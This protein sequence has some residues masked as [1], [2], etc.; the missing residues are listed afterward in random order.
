MSSACTVYRGKRPS[1]ICAIWFHIVSCCHCCNIDDL[2][3]LRVPSEKTRTM[4]T[5]EQVTRQPE[6]TWVYTV[7]TT[8][9]HNSTGPT[10]NLSGNAEPILAKCPVFQSDLV[11][12]AVSQRFP[13]NVSLKCVTNRLINQQNVINWLGFSGTFGTNGLYSALEKVCCS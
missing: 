3:H 7:R 9:P 12:V 13:V 1:I 5:K 6:H 8:C 11:S 2:L 4:H 10:A